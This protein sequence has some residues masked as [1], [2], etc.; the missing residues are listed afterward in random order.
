MTGLSRK[1]LE[2][3][4]DFIT[5]TRIV[6]SRFNSDQLKWSLVAEDGS[7]FG[8][9]DELIINTPP[10]QALPLLPAKSPLIEQVDGIHML[11]CWTLLYGSTNHWLVLLMRF[12]KSGPISWIARNNSKPGRDARETWS[13]RRVTSERTQKGCPA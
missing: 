1:L 6:E 10:Q 11:P 9:F 13:F 12:V 8:P 2:S 7:E 3:A 4:D 5:Q